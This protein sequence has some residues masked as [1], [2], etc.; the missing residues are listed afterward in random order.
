MTTTQ[1]PI[2][3]IALRQQV[4]AQYLRILHDWAEQVAEY[5]ASIGNYPTSDKA[6]WMRAVLNPDWQDGRCEG[7]TDAQAHGW[8]VMWATCGRSDAHEGHDQPPAEATHDYLSTACHH[9]A[10]EHATGNPGRA[11]DLHTHCS[12]MVG[13]AGIKRPAQC[14]W[15]DATCRC[16]GHN[17]Q[18]GTP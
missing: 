11:A 6:L 2:P 8:R 18:A 7:L 1:R 4:P 16:P 14:K 10:Q 17:D 12:A 5:Q 13:Y 9:E 3:A 15:C